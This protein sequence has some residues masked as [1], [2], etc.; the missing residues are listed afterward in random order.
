[1]FLLCRRLSSSTLVPYTTLFRSLTEW[2][3]SAKLSKCHFFKRRMEYLGHEISYE[4]IRPN[5]SKIE[6]ITKMKPPIDI[7]GV[8]RFLG[9]TRSEEHTSELQS[10]ENLVCRLLLE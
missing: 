2:E 8:R 3:L 7:S 6:A 10:R 1:F 4:G 5:Q 9:I